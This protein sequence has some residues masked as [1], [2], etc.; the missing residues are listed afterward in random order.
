MND[1]QEG[2]VFLV[3][4]VPGTPLPAAGRVLAASAEW[5]AAHVWWLDEA[6]D[7]RALARRIGEHAASGEPLF[8]I[9]RRGDMALL[10]QV[11]ALRQVMGY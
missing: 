8:I 7:L 9:S 1:T 3:E 10:N 2:F 5:Q 11:D 6:P 4:D